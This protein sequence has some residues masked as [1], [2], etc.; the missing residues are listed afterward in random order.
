MSPNYV[1][2]YP[3]DRTQLEE[4]EEDTVIKVVEKQLAIDT[5]SSSTVG[6]KQYILCLFLNTMSSDVYI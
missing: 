2:E 4:G 1:Y 6:T 3:G 5:A